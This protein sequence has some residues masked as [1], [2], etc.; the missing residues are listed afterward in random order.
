VQTHRDLR[1]AIV[2]AGIGGLTTA[3]ALAQRGIEGQVYEQA[4]EIKEVGAGIGLGP[5][6]IKILRALSIEA[7]VKQLGMIPE[8]IIGRDWGTGSVLFT[9]P[10]GAEAESRY[11]AANVNLHRADLHAALAA[12]VPPERLQ[13]NRL[14]VAA[15]ETGG[16]V[17]LVFRDGHRETADLVIGCDGLHSRIR[18]SL[19]GPVAP[20]FTGNTAWRALVTA[21]NLPAR[22]IS[23]E[24]NI[25]RGKGG[26][27][28][29]W[30]LPSR[31]VVNLVA[32]RATADW[33]SESWSVSADR[34][35]LL[36]VFPEVHPDLRMLFTQAEPCFK[37][38][39]F[40][41]DPLTRWSSER[42]TLLGD[43]AH[44]TLPFLG[45][46]AAMAIEDAYVLARE[47]AASEG[48]IP[49]ALFSY[50]AKR[51]LRTIRV[52]IASRKEGEILHDQVPPPINEVMPG[53]RF[54]APLLPGFNRDWLYDYDAC[55]G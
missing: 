16:E 30:Y 29:T 51:I 12:R 10:V 26:H 23:T 5:N 49:A 28:L 55:A 18:A 45:Q 39:L 34:D 31:Q 14:C 35:E 21:K 47:L 46:G 4:H 20:R 13:L 33:T 32:I 44:P 17:E 38:G 24:M 9:V 1:I 15:R 22:F 42:I 36:A 52:Q 54:L 40:D 41:R 37:W 43:A 27:I 3:I 8:K 48:N 50:E 2:G 25:W 53:A 7:S 6:A 19:H 11:G